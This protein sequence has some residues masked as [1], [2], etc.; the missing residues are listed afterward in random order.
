MKPDELSAHLAAFLAGET[1]ARVELANVRSMTGGAAREAWSVDASLE[2]PG[3][4]VELQTLVVL[5]FRPGGP[6]AQRG[7]GAREEFR[8]LEA[9]AAAGAPVPRP[10][11]AGEI[12][13]GRAFYAMER[14]TG[15]TIGRRIVR[16]DRFAEARRALPRQLA[17]ALAAIH[18]VP[19]D[20][21]SLAFLPGPAPGEPVAGSELD[22]LEEL[23]R[24]IAVDPHPTFELAFRWLRRHAPA[25]RRRGLVHGDFRIG[26]VIVDERG[27]RAVLDWELAHRGDPLEDLGWLCVRSWRFGADLPVGGVGTR[28]E[29]FEAYERASGAPVDR[30]AVHFW[31][32]YGNLRWGVFTLVQ[33]RGFLDGVAPS[34]ELASIGRRA[35]ETEWELLELLSGRGA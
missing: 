5:V 17:E 32:V 19:L 22:R 24:L 29:L 25:S 15:E 11:Y 23:Y 30:D 35:A 3:S 14:I 7:F 6:G 26:N 27:L 28:E 9:A 20:D 33:V 21:G 18:R 2:R 4:P 31:E 13:P 8:V 16:D 10:M 1:G 34:I 12:A